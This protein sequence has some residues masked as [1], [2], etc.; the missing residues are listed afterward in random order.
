M[1]F[2]FKVM[3]MRLK[4]LLAGA[5]VKK[6]RGKEKDGYEELEEVWDDGGECED[7]D[8]DEEEEEEKQGNSKDEEGS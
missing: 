5:T 6:S 4:S 7:E 1:N 3:F 2:K 8:E